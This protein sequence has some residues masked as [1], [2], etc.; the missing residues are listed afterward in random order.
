M[1]KL[2]LSH[3]ADVTS[4]SDDGKTAIDLAEE[5]GEQSIVVLLRQASQP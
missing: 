1:V 2:L 4:T 3:G 5:K